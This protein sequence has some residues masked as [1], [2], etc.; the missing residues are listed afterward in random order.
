M[1]A[2]FLRHHFSF[3]LMVMLLFS[4]GSRAQMGTTSLHGSVLDKSHQSVGGAKVTLR[5]PS[6]GF[7]RDTV[8]PSSG[9]F[10]FL[11]LPPGTYVLT[12]EK[13]GFQKYEQISLQLLVNVPTT[14]NVV[15]LVGTLSTQVEVSAQTEVINTSDASLGVAFNENQVKQL[16]LESRNVPDLLSLQAGVVY[17]GSR[18]D[19]N[20]DKDTRSGSVNGSHSDQSNVTVDGIPA[21]GK[22]SYA[23]TS[24]LPVTLDSVQ[25]FRVTTSNW[26]ADEGV[27]SGAQVALVTRSGTNSFHGSAY[28]YNRNSYFSAN[29]YFIKKAQLESGSPNKPTKLNRNIF[30]GSL[31]G[32]IKKDRLFL[33]MNFEGY[34]D[35]EA[36]S[37]VRT[38]PTAALRDGVVQY[39]CP[40]KTDG[41]L[42]TSTC[43]GNTVSGL[44]PNSSYTAPA[45]YYALSPQKLTQIDT[46][47]P[48]NPASPGPN[49]IVLAYMKSTYGAFLPNDQTTG[50]LLNTAGYRFRAPTNTRKNWY[51]AKLDYNL[52]SD[53]K[54]RISVS[55][56]L[57]NENAAGAPFLP[58]SAPE[59]D[60]I[61]YNKGIIVGYSSVISSSLINNFRYGFV[62]QSVGTIGDSNKPWNYL[63]AFDQG[64]TYS[65]AFQRPT[66]NFTDDL[67]WIR[68]RHTFQFGF[69]F[70]FLRNPTSNS[71]GVFSSGYANQDWFLNSG[72]STTSSSPLNPGNYLGQLPAVDST[73][74]GNYDSTVTSLLGMI[75]L[76]NAVYNFGRDGKPI[77]AGAPVKRRFAEDSYEMY[78]QDVWKATPNLTITA[79]LRYSLFSPPWETN[80]LQVT[81]TTS[82]NAWFQSRAA[83]MQ[84][85]IPSNVLPLIA[86]DFSG[87]ANGK[88][89]FYGWDL[90]NFGPRLA[91]AWSPGYSSGLLSALFGGKGK[92]SIRAGFGIVYDRVGESLVDTFDQNGSFGLASQLNNPSNVEQSTF[93]PRITDINI[94]PTNDYDPSNP[95]NGNPVLEPN[96]GSSFPKTY[97]AGA[98]AITWGIDNKL[99]T[100]YS[101][102]ID[103]AFSRELRSG[104]SVDVAYVGRLSHRL[105]AQDDLA[106]PLDMY[107][108]KAGIDY[109][110]AEIAL[111]K[112]FRPALKNN[113]NDATAHF[114]PSTLPANV[115]QFWTDQIQPLVPGGA[116][117]ISGCTG[118]DNSGNP[119]VTST[120]NPIVFAYDTFC[121]THFNDSLG[122]YKIDFNGMPDA[123][124][125]GQN[126][127]MA[128]GQYSYYSSQFSSLY[129]WRSIA[130]SSYHALQASLHH[131]M[132]H[133]FQFDFNYTFSKS[134][135][136]SSNAERV[137]AGS[138]S[139]LLEPNSNIINAWNPQNQ[140][141]VSAFDATHQFNANWI[142]EMPFGRGRWIARDVNRVADAF[143]G[144][145]Q[146]SGLFRLTSGFPI[147]VDNGTSNYPTNFELEGNANQISPVHTGVFYNTGNPNIFSTGPGAISSFDYAYAGQAGQRDNIRGN[148]F[149]SVDVGLAKR[150]TMPWSEKHSVQFRWEVFNVTNSVRYD[151]QAGLLAGALGKG[152]GGSFGNYGGLLT[153]PRIMQF[154][155]RYE[156]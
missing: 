29:D 31:G 156:F 65:S 124:I 77:Q 88:A 87:P 81:P 127:Y 109:F 21:N 135:D 107:D 83:G 59:R 38:V 39:L 66:N 62:R 130:P 47:V 36:V 97:P 84:Q 112:A 153:N 118:V 120:T 92:S 27:S 45:G 40:L 71:N 23:F 150:W 144:G 16:P 116:Y 25:E 106:M 132:S 103:L 10:E 89:G 37:A 42:D 145:W 3:L 60:T 105:L 117:Q 136:I 54:H 5:N 20:Q 64:V 53:A 119:I 143:I 13:D 146:L 78:F 138:N 142:L 114:N 15:L 115:Q 46:L 12:V 125:P 7:Q 98:G 148:G 91:L 14:V 94:V 90:H 73:F 147:S 69:Q 50:D 96:G 110:T 8:T 56:A 18:P 74:Q 104:F 149:F 123:N 9:D 140:R 17:T 44:T 24:V 102:T 43:P 122:L 129:A 32:P 133:G 11:A 121:S 108:K 82:L 1:R 154:A 85:G 152:S 155:L 100:P 126:Y 4:A 33:F 68:G 22:G 134:I 63:S 6:Q 111:A 52:T 19:I 72:L 141:G 79:G 137:G 128:G 86:Y 49:P 93:A 48:G 2:I 41:S 80:G 139:S 51:I 75:T 34:R 113:Q 95:P 70:S 55:A 57:A 131:A 26:G 28:E 76:G 30:G 58:G 101:Y 61:D 151:V 35:V 67:S 99:K